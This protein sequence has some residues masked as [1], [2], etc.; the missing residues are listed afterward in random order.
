MFRQLKPDLDP[1]VNTYNISLFEHFMTRKNCSTAVQLLGITRKIIKKTVK[2][3]QNVI[4]HS[5]HVRFR[6]K[7]HVHKAMCVCLLCAH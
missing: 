2:N 3:K 7:T 4:F 6:S 1:P 5:L